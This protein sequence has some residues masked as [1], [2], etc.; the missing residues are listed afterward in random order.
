MGAHSLSM[1]YRDMESGTRHLSRSG[2]EDGLT[3]VRGEASRYVKCTSPEIPSRPGSG[4]RGD[5]LQDRDRVI[6]DTAKFAPNS[7]ISYH[8]TLASDAGKRGG[9]QV[10]YGY[11]EERSC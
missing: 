11:N 8:A 5:T 1:P 10:E 2:N 4:W 6:G 9:I 3:S 7:P